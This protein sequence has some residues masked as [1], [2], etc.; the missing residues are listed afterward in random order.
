M[1]EK[2]VMLG[3][4]SE[5]LA[6]AFGLISLSSESPIRVMKNLRICSDCHTFSKYVSQITQREIIVR[7]KNR[8]HHFKAGFCSCKDFW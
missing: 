6:I 4:H 8:F 7:D 3:T 2:E 5:K 1:E